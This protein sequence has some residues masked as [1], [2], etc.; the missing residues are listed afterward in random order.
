MGDA[1]L[2]IQLEPK[3][4]DEPSTLRLDIL[5]F[6]TV[7]MMAQSMPEGYPLITREKDRTACVK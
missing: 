2:P 1:G 3:S 5:P 4:V 7:T 6:D